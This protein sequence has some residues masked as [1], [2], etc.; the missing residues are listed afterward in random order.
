MF[1]GL[2]GEQ[3]PDSTDLKTLKKNKTLQL[4]NVILIF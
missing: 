4:K 1:C 2:K 3:D